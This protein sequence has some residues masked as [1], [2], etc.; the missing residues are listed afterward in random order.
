MFNWPKI[1][2]GLHRVRRAGYPPYLNWRPDIEFQ[3]FPNS[4][5]FPYHRPV[6]HRRQFPR[7]LR[8]PGDPRTDEVVIPGQQPRP[9]PRPNP[10]PRPYPWPGFPPFPPPGPESPPV[11][12]PDVVIGP[13]PGTNPGVGPG[14]GRSTSSKTG[15][16]ARPHRWQRPGRKQK[17]IKQKLPKWLALSM[18]AAWGVTEAVD[19]V[20]A[21]WEALPDHI[22]DATPMTGVVSQSGMNPGMKYRHALDKAQ[23]LY[24]N[25]ELLDQK[26]G[27]LNL[28]KNHIIDFIIGR[29]SQGADKARRRA[30]GTA[31]WGLAT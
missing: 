11:A 20:D 19:A 23:V 28:V 26:E 22:K 27:G 2:P 14:T 29:I 24:D 21:L 17:E 6:W 30:G 10:R 5:P 1:Y 9:R 4:N 15:I 25:W 8:R 18:E 31:G 13:R 3:P 7:P 16:R 12:P